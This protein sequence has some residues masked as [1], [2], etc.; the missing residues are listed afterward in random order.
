MRKLARCAAVL[1]MCV[2][3]C[4][5]HAATVIP[6]GN[7]PMI[8][9]GGSYVLAQAVASIT[10]SAN[11][12]DLDLGG[13][14]VGNFGT[15]VLI[16]GGVSAG[17][18]G[19]TAGSA[20]GIKV[21]GANVTIHNGR[22]EGALGDGIDVYASQ[23]GAFV[24]VQIN[25]VTVDNNSGYGI[26]IFGTGASLSNVKAY[27]NLLDGILLQD[28]VR[29]EHVTAS[30]NNGAGVNGAA[31]AGNYYDVMTARNKTSGIVANGSLAKVNAKYNGGQGMV[32]SGV[33]R[34][35]S[36]E[37]NGAEG[38]NA[39]Q[40]GLVVDSASSQNTGNGFTLGSATCYRNL[41]ANQNTGSAV[42]GGT[43]LTGTLASCN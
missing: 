24:N 3:G 10:V 33:L 32:V 7:N 25:D 4:G 12:V 17:C 11:N 41:S 19:G 16:N 20:P 14:R 5:A 31:G 8:S 21:T 1:S 22:V 6:A 39:T 36:A 28:Q 34:D 23:P 18:S 40:R 43:P 35:S 37:F 13:Y 9:V 27:Q 29:L 26:A 2:L 15:C 30:Y 38:V 42:S